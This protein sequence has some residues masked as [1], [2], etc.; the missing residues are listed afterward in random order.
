M[1]DYILYSFELDRL[2]KEQQRKTQSSII[3]NNNDI[4]GRD[5]SASTKAI[6]FAQNTLF[7][8]GI[9]C[10]EAPMHISSHISE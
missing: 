1:I 4:L 10:L 9:A 6:L 5:I 8:V 7:W 3:T 2:K